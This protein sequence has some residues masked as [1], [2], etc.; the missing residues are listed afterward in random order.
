MWENGVMARDYSRRSTGYGSARF[1]SPCHTDSGWL[2]ALSIVNRFCRALLYG[3]SPLPA[4]A[5]HD[6]EMRELER[7]KVDVG[8][9]LAMRATPLALTT[10]MRCSM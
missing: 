4:V 7:I 2:S 9:Y 10:V 6:L 8:R 3:Y 1:A 5:H